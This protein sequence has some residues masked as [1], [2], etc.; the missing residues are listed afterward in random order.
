MRRMLRREKTHTKHN[1]RES[2]KPFPGQ[3]PP[4]G[5]SALG[6]PRTVGDLFKEWDWE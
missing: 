6:G 2:L 5:A 4:A 3:V 1:N